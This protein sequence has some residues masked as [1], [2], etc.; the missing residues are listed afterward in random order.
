MKKILITG[1]SG[2]IGRNLK[3]GLKKTFKIY[4]PKSSELDLLDSENVEKYMKKN[5]FDI[6]IHAATHNATRVSSKSL[7]EVFKNNLTMFFNLRRL[8]SYYGRMFYFGSGAEYDMGNYKPKMGEDY[9]DTFV[10]KDDYGF[11]KYI[12][13]KSLSP[14]GNVYDLILFGCFGKYE[15]YRIRYISNAICRSILGEEITLS[16]DRK[17]DYLYVK[18]L[19]EI[20]KILIN[21][22][23]LKYRRY[24]ICTGNS[25]E[26]LSLGKKIKEASNKNTK[27]VVAK[28]GLGAEYSG[29]NSRLIE[30]IGNFKF[31]PVK[32]SIR[33]LYFWYLK[34]KNKLNRKEII[35]YT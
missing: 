28:K 32:D 21:K 17:L 18:D 25:I 2:F 22:K 24:N 26:L 10:P 19:I 30:E 27:I 33:E 13:A 1:A 12:M 31:F 6:V 7:S 16:Q 4:S 20:I 14:T 9:F 34:N 29:N 11:S 3:E 35:K 23:K 5:N 15:D 8:T